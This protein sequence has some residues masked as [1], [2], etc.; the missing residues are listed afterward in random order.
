[1][2]ALKLRQLIGSKKFDYAAAI[3][4]SLIFCL[5]RFLCLHCSSFWLRILSAVLLS[6]VAAAC[7]FHF[8]ALKRYLPC[9]LNLFLLIRV[10][11]IMLNEA[12]LHVSA[13]IRGLPFRFVMGV[14]DYNGE[15]ITLVIWCTVFFFCVFIRLLWPGAGAKKSKDGLDR[16]FLQTSEMFAL[17]YPFLMLFFLFLIRMQRGTGQPPN[18]IPF[19]IIVM[20]FTKWKALD[21]SLILFFG[22]IFL[23]SPPGFYFAFKKPGKKRFL[24]WFPVALSCGIELSQLVFDLGHCDI[25]DVLLNSLG[26]YIGVWIKLFLDKTARRVSKGAVKKIF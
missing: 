19:K 16:F 1:M 11:C 26:F 4:L 25:D 5:I 9:A 7:C 20:Y 23:F 12:F 17:Y 2:L 24:R 10:G 18:F 6:A 21:V 15:M 14:Y 13:L 3:S 8:S 22:N